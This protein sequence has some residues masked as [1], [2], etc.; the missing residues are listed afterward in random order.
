MGIEA[1][2]PFELPLV[3]TVNRV[4]IFVGNVAV[5]VKIQLY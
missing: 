4:I 5:L 2:D 1:I 3:N